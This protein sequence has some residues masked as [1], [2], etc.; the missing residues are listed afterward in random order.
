MNY[1]TIILSGILHIIL[2]LIFEGIFLFVILYPILTKI[3]DNISKTISRKIFEFLLKDPNYSN[4]IVN[5]N[6]NNYYNILIYNNYLL[7][8]PNL[9][10]NSNVT[11]ILKSGA[12]DEKI[13]ITT[14]NYM[15]YIIFIMLE[16]LLIITGII[17]IYIANRFNIKIDYM[18]IIINSII[19]FGLICGVAFFIL[20]T[21]V[22][23]QPYS[24]DIN[25][26]LYSKFLEIYYSA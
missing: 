5:P 24:M 14:E 20:W 7:D 9:K 11:Y 25:S 22:F 3:S 6:K 10:F 26:K 4:L 2:V 21:I 1:P 18:F 17:L 16:V 8:N 15:P 12:T 13:Y 19:V 23:T